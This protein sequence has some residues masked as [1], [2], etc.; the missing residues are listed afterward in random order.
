MKKF[1][2]GESEFYA[3]E[4]D[5]TKKLPVFYNPVMSFDR[6]L[7]IA[8]LKEFSKETGAD[9][10]CDCLAA[11][12]IRGLRAAKE[13]GI[14]DVRINDINPSAVKLAEKN[15]ALNGAK[16]QVS[17]RDANL[18]LREIENGTLDIIDIDPFGPFAPFLDSALRAVNKKRGLLCLSATDTAPLCGV[19]SKTCQRRY[20]AKPARTSYAKEVGLRILIGN[21]ARAAARYDFAIRPLLCYS[22]RH[23]F[24]LYLATEAGV[25]QSD[26]MLEKISY[27]QY[28][29]KCDWRD[30]AKTCGFKESCPSCKSK[31]SWAGPLWAAEFA[32][33]GF[34][35]KLKTPNK[36]AAKLIEII[37][38]EQGIMT[39]FYELHH[40]S[41]VYKSA[42]PKTS[43][44][45]EKLSSLG[46]KTAPT[47]FSKTGLRSEAI[48]VF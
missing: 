27:L 43:A 20:D 24:R 25:P 35:K 44:V 30:Y 15:L 47:H 18:F 46:K 36:E 19:A 40:L 2:E 8:V 9:S 1:K 17:C 31:L 34:L 22:H 37:S 32:D 28:C 4:G 10:Y 42:I 11:S 23:Y 12:G 41:E 26:R 38:G 21:C 3:P 39:P 13:A 29:P 48:P 33:A 7:T 16:A 6:D 14:K 45:V 5:I